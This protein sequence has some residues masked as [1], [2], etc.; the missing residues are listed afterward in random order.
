MDA[1]GKKKKTL[2]RILAQKS[3]DAWPPRRKGKIIFN[4]KRLGIHRTTNEK[5]I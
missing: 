3:Q 4:P 2:E 5:Y 1:M